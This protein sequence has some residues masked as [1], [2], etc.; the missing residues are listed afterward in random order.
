M[1]EAVGES[2]H[3][4]VDEVLRDLGGSQAVE[5][6]VDGVVEDGAVL[7]RQSV[8]EVHEVALG[9]LVE[10]SKRHGVKF[11]VETDDAQIEAFLGRGVV[12]GLG[13]SAACEGGEGDNECHNGHR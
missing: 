3:R 8:N 10:Q 2:H 4:D 1:V 13:L 11:L 9:V 7:H 12:F 5:A 6:R